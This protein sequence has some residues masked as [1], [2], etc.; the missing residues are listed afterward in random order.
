MCRL[1]GFSTG[2][3][4]EL[5]YLINPL[6]VHFAHGNGDGAGF[7]YTDD[8]LVTRKSGDTALQFVMNNNYSIDSKN[9]IAHVRAATGTAVCDNNSHPF[10]SCDNK[11]ALAHNG[12]IYDYETAKRELEKLGHKFKTD[13]DSEILLHAYEEHGDNFI[14][15][16]N[17]K[18]VNGWANILIL[19]E[20]GTLKVYSGGSIFVKR[21][22]TGVL[23]TQE[24][25]IKESEKVK[26]GWLLRF[27][28]GILEETK[29]IGELNAFDL[30]DYPLSWGTNFKNYDNSIACQR[31]EE[32]LTDTFEIPWVNTVVVRIYRKRN[33]L[34]EILL[35][36]V[37]KKK[38]KVIRKL[39]PFFI[40]KESDNYDHTLIATINEQKFKDKMQKIEDEYQLP[41]NLY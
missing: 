39:M 11:I 3:K 34:L 36:N 21:S 25:V 24:E 38:S 19:H 4:R 26:D 2:N 22:E 37:P 23:I 30:G 28:D 10:V 29:F 18:Q 27:K 14:N 35:K 7:S 33:T 12:I 31:Y 9:V 40:V 1:I 17:S 13:V 16:L 15:W 5:K 8:E 20:D 6:L 32:M 41:M